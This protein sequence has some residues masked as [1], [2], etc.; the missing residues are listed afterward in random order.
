MTFVRK[1]SEYCIAGQGVMRGK[2]EISRAQRVDHFVDV[3]KMVGLIKG[4]DVGGLVKRTGAATICPHGRN[5]VLR[6]RLQAVNQSCVKYRLAK[7][8]S[9][10]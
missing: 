7:S 6:S 10:L 8:S 3:N 2:L 1:K 9:G 5:T 4:T